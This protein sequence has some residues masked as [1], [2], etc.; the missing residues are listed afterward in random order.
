VRFAN[1][2]WNSNVLR[3]IEKN[4]L[5]FSLFLGIQSRHGM[6]EQAFV[7]CLP[8]IAAA[9]QVRNW[10]FHDNSNQLLSI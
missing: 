4:S 9:T 10:Q 7:A 1:F 2:G 5:L 6:R 3:V 8:D